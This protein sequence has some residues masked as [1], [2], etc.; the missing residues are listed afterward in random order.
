VTFAELER[1]AS[2]LKE[3]VVAVAGAAGEE[4]FGALQV[5]EQMLPVRFL[6]VGDE[7]Q[8]RQMAEHYRVHPA[9]IIHAEGDEECAKLAVRAVT[10]GRAA[11][12]MKGLVSTPVLLKQIV[13][14]KRLFEPGE[15]LSHITV[16]E[17]PEGRLFAITDGGMNLAPDADQKAKIVTSA[18]R[19]FHRFGVEQP[20]VAVLA[21]N[22]KPNPKI[23][24]SAD[25]VEL[26]RRWEE[27]AFPESVVDGPLALDLAVSPHAAELKGYNGPVRGDADILLVS[28][29]TCGNV[30]G[31]SL[32]YLAGYP[33]AGMILGARVPII[34]LSRSDSAREKYQSI[35]LALTAGV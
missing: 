13:S 18:I 1:E 28:D 27:G 33:G 14:E 4:V 10:E 30:L 7:A 26:K 32:V 24:G 11:L 22:E 29:I 19:L 12:L 16:L 34:L 31:K 2:R 25:A 20:R 8:C 5:A 9:G 15:L 23:P 17:H 3:Q 6:L 35:L 21:A